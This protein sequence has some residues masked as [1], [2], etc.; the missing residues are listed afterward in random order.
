MSL[1]IIR[2]V[3]DH[4]QHNGPRL[5]V[6]LVLADYA[7]KEHVAWPSYQTLGKKA[8]MNRRNVIRIVK[9]LEQSGELK[10]E[11]RFGHSNRY[12]FCLNSGVNPDTR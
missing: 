12:R 10:V 4:S 7:N 6:L 5:L 3:F 11:R 8:R 1:Q 2:D 9:D